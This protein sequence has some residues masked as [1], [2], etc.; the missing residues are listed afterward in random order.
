MREYTFHED[1]GHGWLEVPAAELV[2]L[3]IHEQISPSPPHI[4]ISC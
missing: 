1:A 2:S 4:R 3:G